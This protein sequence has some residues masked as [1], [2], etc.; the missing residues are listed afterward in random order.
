MKKKPRRL[1][2]ASVGIHDSLTSHATRISGA[3]PES[4]VRTQRSIRRLRGS[5]AWEGNFQ[6]SRLGR[7]TK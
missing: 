5:V 3:Q 1:T 4:A 6:E 2:R 7:G